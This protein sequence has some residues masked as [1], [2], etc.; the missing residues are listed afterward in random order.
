MLTKL[1][2]TAKGGIVIAIARKLG[3][4]PPSLNP[5][6]KRSNEPSNYSA[7]APAPGGI[8]GWIRDKIDSIRGGGRGRGS[9]GA[10]GR[11]DTARAVNSRK[12]KLVVEEGS[13]DELAM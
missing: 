2:G 6:A 9:G 8:Q 7:P 11:Q 1:D 10:K 3:L 13:E 12:R 4:P 5:F